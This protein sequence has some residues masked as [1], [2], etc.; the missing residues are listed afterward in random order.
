M[1]DRTTRMRHQAR[2]VASDRDRHRAGIA[3]NSI[4]GDSRDSME[5]PTLRQHR[6]SPCRGCGSPC[7]YGVHDAAVVS[8]RWVVETAVAPPCEGAVSHPTTYSIRQVGRRCPPD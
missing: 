7:T 2:L 6:G 8:G 4:M 1:A 5:T 3:G